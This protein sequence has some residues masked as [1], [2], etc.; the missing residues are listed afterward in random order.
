MGTPHNAKMS[1]TAYSDICMTGNASGASGTFPTNI[2][3]EEATK[4]VAG[5]SSMSMPSGIFIGGKKYMFLRCDGEL[6]MG[7]AGQDGCSIAITAQAIVV[8]IYGEG[9]QG[10]ANSVACG[11]AADALKGQGY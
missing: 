11:A 7:K 3:V 5:F 6:M 2:S 1:W 4:I 8:S 10:E 9:M